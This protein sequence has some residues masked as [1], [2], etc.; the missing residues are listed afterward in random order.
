MVGIIAVAGSSMFLV[1]PS[2]PDPKSSLTIWDAPSVF[3][4]TLT[5]MF[6]A[7]VVFLPI[8]LGYTAVVLRH[9]VRNT[10]DEIEA[11]A[12]GLLRPGPSERR[13]DHV[14]LRLDP[15]RHRAAA[16]IV[17]SITMWYEFQDG[18]TARLVRPH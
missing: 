5:V 3:H 8:V 1:M 11:H 16:A 6:W 13:D 12:F 10:A 17:G 2:S 14:V 18:S 4:L 15:R 7:V 9:H